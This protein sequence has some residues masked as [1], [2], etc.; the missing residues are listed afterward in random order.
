MLDVSEAYIN[1]FPATKHIVLT[2]YA[3]QHLAIYI[4]DPFET[5]CFTALIA[6]GIKPR[7]IRFRAKNTAELFEL[8]FM[9]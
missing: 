1:V 9:L 2:L 7:V 4:L 8:G 3:S 6:P 5:A